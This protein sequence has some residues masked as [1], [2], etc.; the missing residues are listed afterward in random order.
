MSISQFALVSLLLTVGCSSSSSPASSS[1]ETS[2]STASGRPGQGLATKSR[3]RKCRRHT[4]ALPDEARSDPRK[5]LR[6]GLRRDGEAPA[7]S[8]R[9]GLQPHAVLH[10]Q[11]CAARHQ[12]RVDQALRRAIEQASED[13]DCSRFTLPSCRSSRDQLFP[14]LVAGKV[15]FVAAALTITPERESSPTSA[16]RRARVCRRLS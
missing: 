13:R 11:R 10:R 5:G 14:S 2:P 4:H 1:T 7:D 16:T 12:L 6:R 9:C 8:G 15:D 3:F